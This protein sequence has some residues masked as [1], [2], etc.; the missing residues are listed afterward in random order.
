MRAL[1]IDIGTTSIC[2][3]GYEEGAEGLPFVTNRQNTFL[4]GTFEQDPEAI[5]DKVMD[6]L[7][8]AEQKGFGA[9]RIDAVGISSQM[10]GIVYIDGEGR[11]VSPLYTWKDEKGKEHMGDGMSY[12]AFLRLHTGLPLYSGYGTVTH[13]YLGKKGRIPEGAERFAGIGDYVA[14]RLTGRKAP[15]VEESM[16]AGFGGFDLGKG[17]FVLDRLARTGVDVGFYPELSRQGERAGDWE[18]VPVCC[19]VGDNQAS[20]YGAVDRPEEQVSINVGTGSQVSV[21]DSRLMPAQGV[22]IRPFFGSGYLYVGASLNGGKV[23]ER[24]A[25][26]FEETVEAFTG[27]RV[28]AYETMA[29][30]GGGKRDTA[31]RIRP[32]LYGERGDGAENT[33]ELGGMNGLTFDTFHPADLIR[34]YVRGM[35]D[36]L[37]RLYERFPAEIRKGKQEIVASGNGI[38]KNP[39]LAQEVAGRFGMKVVIGETQEEAA[40]GAARAALRY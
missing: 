22:E 19:A 14:M 23:Y 17:G 28:N 1:G 8:E 10:H 20:F 36:E 34:A 16:A 30:L 40:A 25:A 29:R 32:L 38:R 4:D 6:M 9:S 33:G 7:A 35:A 13:F 39:L 15:L 2:M 18:G 37:Y 3:A 27:E 31:L 21:F 26:F 12:E 11:A 5:I 24:L